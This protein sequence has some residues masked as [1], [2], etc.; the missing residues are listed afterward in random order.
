V[1]NG[2]GKDVSWYDTTGKSTAFLK[3][4]TL[5]STAVATGAISVNWGGVDGAKGYT[6]YRKVENGSWVKLKSVGSTTH[7]YQDKTVMAGQKYFYTVRAYNDSVTSGWNDL[8]I[9]ATAK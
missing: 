8:G 2:S 9:S 7:T 4:P 3:I 6:V 5:K 1:R